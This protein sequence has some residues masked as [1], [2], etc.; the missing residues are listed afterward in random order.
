MEP[1]GREVRRWSS[2]RANEP[3][4]P[5]FDTVSPPLSEYPQRSKAEPL[6]RTLS[7]GAH[8][9]SRS[10]QRR[11]IH[12]WWVLPSPLS[13]PVSYFAE[14]ICNYTRMHKFSYVVFPTQPAER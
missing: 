9:Y 3:F 10:Q 14:T 13:G 6:S 1:A 12:Q 5:R 8:Y 11:A 4:K 2:S 7:R